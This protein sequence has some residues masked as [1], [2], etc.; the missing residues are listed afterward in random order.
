MHLSDIKRLHGNQTQGLTKK[1]ELEAF[2]TK[3][4]TSSARLSFMGFIKKL[5][6]SFGFR[7]QLQEVSKGEN[8]LLAENMGKSLILG[9][10][11]V[12]DQQLLNL[13]GSCWFESF[14]HPMS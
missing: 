11:T 7:Q 10:L 1:I 5:F 3:L 4:R 12:A 13:S 8:R 6:K 2:R 9:W 14:C